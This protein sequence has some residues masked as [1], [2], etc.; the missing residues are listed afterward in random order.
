MTEVLQIEKQA[1]VGHIIIDSPPVNA[2][3]YAV[4]KGLDD[5]MDALLADDTVKAII[6]RCDGRTFFAGADISEFGKP[7]R[8]PDLHGV[9]AKIEFSAKPVIAALHGTALGGGM[10]LALHCHYRVAADTAAMGL[11]EVHLGL[12]PGA[13]GTQRLPRIVG[14]RKALDMMALGAP[15]RADEALSLGLV[16]EVIATDDLVA[17]AQR[18]A[19]TVIAK[20]APLPDIR[21]RQDKVEADRADPEIFSAFRARHARR[22]KGFKAPENIIKAVEAAISLPYAQGVEREAELFVELLESKES[23]AQRHVFFAERA[24]SKIPGLD[25]SVQP[26]PVATTGVLG[27]GTMGRGITL[28]LSAA[29][30]PVT[31]VDSNAE[32][33]DRTM[34]IIRKTCEGAVAKGRMSPEKAEAQIARITPA[35]DAKAFADCDLVIE[36]VFEDMDLK[37]S[38]FSTLDTIVKPGALLASNTSFLDLDKIAAATKRPQ[39]VIGLHFFSP[40]NIMPLL[41]IVRGDKTSDAALVTA[42]GLAKRLRKTPVVSGVCDGFIANR[43]MAPRMA[44]A[45]RLILEGISPAD[46]D[47]VCL[48]Y[49]FPMGPFQMIDLVGLDVIGRNANE[50]TVRSELVRMGRLGQKQK[51][52]YYDYPAASAPTPS[53]EAAAVI[54][55]IAAEAGLSQADLDDDGL[56]MRLL[57]PVV[58]EGARILE[59]GMALRASDIDIALIKGYNWPI[60]KGGPMLWA[61]Q[62]G[63]GRII[64]T[65]NAMAADRGPAFT[66]SPLL[67]RLQAEGGRLSE[68]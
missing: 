50:K 11:P 30:Y 36:A 5:G 35:T 42:L 51:G 8:K 21:T 53:P 22:F 52:G 16:D 38:I 1:G 54:A 17:S 56:L 61:D 64:D 32:A 25:K 2:L 10:E 34:G 24:T 15:V 44:E 33:L 43:A 47:R 6:I 63:L 12:L 19:E 68:Q 9:L 13:A 45:D 20:A 41:E 37:T 7:V 48:N 27:A 31:I 58:N 14:A 66:P 18:F 3:G 29:G 55:E 40:A 59:E 28:A 23:E 49:G 4:R 65:L 62:V 46:I 67:V 26:M 57:S 60:Y 39:D